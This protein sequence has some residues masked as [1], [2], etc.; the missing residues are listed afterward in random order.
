MHSTEY[1]FTHINDEFRLTTVQIVYHIP[2]YFSIL[3]TFVW[4]T[5]DYSPEY[6]RIHNFL[7]YWETNIEASIHSVQIG[8]RPLTSED[9]IKT[10]DKYYK[11]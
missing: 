11:I 1:F 4:Q 8:D 6:P 3:Q 5:L 9:T 2:D 10:V 7:S